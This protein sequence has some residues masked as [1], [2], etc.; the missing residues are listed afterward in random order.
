MR[1][2]QEGPDLVAKRLWREGRP[3]EEAQALTWVLGWM[4]GIPL[5]WGLGGGRGRCGWR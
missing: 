1:D 5:R 3:G 2:R 4:V